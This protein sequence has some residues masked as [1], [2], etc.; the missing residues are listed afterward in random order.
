MGIFNFLNKKQKST[1]VSTRN[2]LIE[3][4]YA[5]DKC[6]NSVLQLNAIYKLSKNYCISAS[7]TGEYSKCNYFIQIIVEDTRAMNMFVGLFITNLTKLKCIE[8]IIIQNESL[9]NLRQI[10]P[11]KLLA[12]YK[13]ASSFLVEKNRIIIVQIVDDYPE[14][15]KEFFKKIDD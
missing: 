1:Y 8:K 13:I 11:S 2:I 12:F 10:L 15:S 3:K 6:W 4:N 9:F 5:S 7:V 14:T